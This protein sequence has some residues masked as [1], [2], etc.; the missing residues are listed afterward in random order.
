METLQTKYIRYIEQ[1]RDTYTPPSPVNLSLEQE[2]VLDFIDNVTNDYEKELSFFL[3]FVSI[4]L[5]QSDRYN[6]DT[7]LKNLR[8]FLEYMQQG[9]CQ[10]GIIWDFIYNSD[11]KDFYIKHI[12]DIENAISN[13]ESDYGIVSNNTW[14]PRYTFS[15]WFV[16][17]QFCDD[18][19]SNF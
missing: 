3:P 16:F 8:A 7:P 1:S 17:E 4:I 15:V 5:Y 6:T 13:Y 12:D 14:T 18:L 11:C 9:W 2:Q 19:L 10:S